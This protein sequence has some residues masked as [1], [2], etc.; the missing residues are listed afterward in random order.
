MKRL[1]WILA[2][3]FG[4]VFLGATAMNAA[5]VAKARSALVGMP[6]IAKAEARSFQIAVILPDTNDSFFKGI[7]DGVSSEA[8]D[9]DVAV[10][11]FRYAGQSAQE[12]DRY[13]EI[14]LRSKVDGIVM[15]RSRS[16]ASP[17]LAGEAKADE[18]A[19]LGV[20]YIP[21]GTDAPEDE[22]GPFIGSGSRLQGF[23]GGRLIG[24]KLGGRVRV[25]VILS[26]SGS[27]LPEDE[28]LYRGLVTALRGYPGA[29]V[30]DLAE[31]EPGMLSGEAVAESMLRAH[32]DIN[33][34]LC[35]NAQDTVGVVQVLLDLNKVGAVLVVGADET[36]DIRRYI[37]KGVILASIVR[38]SNK[39]GREAVLTF[40]RIKKGALVPAPKETGFFVVAGKKASR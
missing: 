40:S 8:A 23:E 16:E 26:G 13:F 27:G 6:V 1:S 17:A 9:A 37:D 32:P 35:S 19:R 38:D 39:I 7:L 22:S 36:E 11:V 3:A 30:V 14:A 18:A 5:L 15:Y 25:G 4:L 28:P 10:Q 21:V 34:M 31:A 20:V 24:K 29:I 33:A 12:A 2:L